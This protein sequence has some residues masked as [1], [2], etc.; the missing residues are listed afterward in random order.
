MSGLAKILR[1]V[2]GTSKADVEETVHEAKTERELREKEVQ[3]TQASEKQE[4]R[5]GRKIIAAVDL[6]DMTEKQ[7]MSLFNNGGGEHS[8][9]TDR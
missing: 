9:D 4:R 3:E 8:E 6:T 1:I 2:I 5:R 7:F